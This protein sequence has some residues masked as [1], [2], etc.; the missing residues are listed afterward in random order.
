MVPLQIYMQVEIS[1]WLENEKSK[2]AMKAKERDIEMWMNSKELP[3]NIMRRVMPHVR[4]MI[5]EKKDIDERN[6][7]P[8]LPIEFAKEIKRHICWPLLKRVSSTPAPPIFSYSL[9]KI[10]KYELE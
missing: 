9:L 2:E 6:P 1:I 4:R 5:E 10:I 7:L 8:H 3:L